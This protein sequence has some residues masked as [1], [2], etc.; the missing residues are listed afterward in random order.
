MIRNTVARRSPRCA[1]HTASNSIEVGG[2][3]P[4]REQRGIVEPNAL[5]RARADR[6]EKR[7]H[8]STSRRLARVID[9]V[10]RRDARDGIRRMRLERRID[11]HDRACA[12]NR[13]ITLSSAQRAS[14]W[15][16]AAGSAA[17][18]KE[19]RRSA[20]ADKARE[21]LVEDR[22]AG[23]VERVVRQLVDDRVRQV[24]RVGARATSRAAD[25]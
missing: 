1:T 10:A 6:L 24:E 13:A 25:R 18:P 3:D 20:R 19:P 8:S 7:P 16:A 21:R 22:L 17:R 12:Q 14:T 5:E 23:R 9:G 2:V 15:S 11:A 4:V